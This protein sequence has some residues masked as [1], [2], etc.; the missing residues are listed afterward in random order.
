MT[1]LVTRGVNFSPDKGFHLTDA[2]TFSSIFFVR[3]LL[4]NRR[5]WFFSLPRDTRCRLSD[6][7]QLDSIFCQR[8]VILGCSCI[9]IPIIVTASF[10]SGVIKHIPNSPGNAGYPG[11]YYIVPTVYCAVPNFWVLQTVLY[12]TQNRYYVQYPFGV[13]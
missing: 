13:L 5:S 6:F 2:R 12:S 9:T 1:V 8:E 10:G 4:Y 3:F 7:I 11:G